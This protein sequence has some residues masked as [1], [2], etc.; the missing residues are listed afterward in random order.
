[1]KKI[2][3]LVGIIILIMIIGCT[4]IPTQEMSDARQ[5]LNA[6]NHVNAKYYAPSKWQQAQNNLKQAEKHLINNQ[7]KQARTYAIL[8]KQQAVSAYNLAVNIKSKQ[9]SA[10][11]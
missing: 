2:S 11:E 6:A 7:F 4:T 1:M 3:K 9:V 10:L 5:T 8:V